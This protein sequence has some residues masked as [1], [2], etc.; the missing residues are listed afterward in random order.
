MPPKSWNDAKPQLTRAPKFW[1]FSSGRLINE[2]DWSSTAAVTGLRY[3]SPS[4]LA[5][6]SC[7]D[8]CIRVMDLETRKVI[9][10]LSGC[11]GQINDF[12][13]SNNG[14]WILSA[15]MDSVVRVWD[16]PTGHLIDAFRVASTCTTLDFS[17]TGELLAMAHADNIGISIWN[18][19]SLFTSVPQRNL[20][21]NDIT[22][23]FISPSS[24]EHCPTAIEAAFEDESESDKSEHPVLSLDKLGKDL[25][26]LSI[27]PRSA[28]QTLL[29]L[30]MIMASLF[31]N[32]QSLIDI[33]FTN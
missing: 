33:F 15:S 25:M 16:L 30:D 22:D 23:A 29:Q 4:E 20:S 14:Q 3:S 6:F 18:N 28:W 9:R 26:T 32:L 19:R 21:E 11:I 10:E 7:D 24:G 13:F 17:A 8:L 12:C 2:I 27:I 31:G 5:A 1:D